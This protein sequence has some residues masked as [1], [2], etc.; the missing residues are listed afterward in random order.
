[1]TFL[2]QLE[3][4]AGSF[5]WGS[6]GKAEGQLVESFSADIEDCCGKEQNLQLENIEKGSLCQ[7]FY[8]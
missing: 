6:I 2:L 7:V 5:C 1:L 8:F 4:T 3:S